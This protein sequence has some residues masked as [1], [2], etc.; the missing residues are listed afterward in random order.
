MNNRTC[1][2]VREVR[3]WTVGHDN[4][5]LFIEPI[6][7]PKFEWH[8]GPPPSVTLAASKHFWCSLIRYTFH[9][10]AGRLA[11]YK[12]IFGSFGSA[13]PTI[14]FSAL[15]NVLNVVK[16]VQENTL[17]VTPLLQN[18]HFYFQLVFSVTDK[19][20]KFVYV[21][22]DFFLSVNSVL[23]FFVKLRKLLHFQCLLRRWSVSVL[24]IWSKLEE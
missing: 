19:T 15:T 23:K 8:H 9:S 3:I 5:L 14:Y 2:T 10:L 18:T 12:A 16:N 11:L 24:D 7:P 4:T 20:E 1:A 6:L 17:Q 13:T 22:V 21:F